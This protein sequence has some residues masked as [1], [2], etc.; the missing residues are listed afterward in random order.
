M[1]K[2][3]RDRRWLANNRQ[4]KNAANAAWNTANPD[5]VRL[6]NRRYA[7]RRRGTPT[8][9]CPHCRT[10]VA[11]RVDGSVYAHNNTAGGRCTGV[12]RIAA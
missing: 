2:R 4:R 11:L 1:S 10:P 7:H 8:G 3:D 12:G 6:A 9:T 5:A